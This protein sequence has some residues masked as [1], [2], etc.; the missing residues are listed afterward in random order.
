MKQLIL[1]LLLSLC[2]LSVNAQDYNEYLEAAQKHLNNGDYENA[3][4]SYNVYKRLTGRTIAKYE[5]IGVSKVIGQV[6]YIDM[7]FP[8]GTKW[9]SQNETQRCSFDNALK[10]Y[11][12]SVLP[13]DKQWQELSDWCNWKWYER[14]GIYGYVLTSKINGNSIFLPADIPY[15]QFHVKDSRFENAASASSLELYS[16]GAFFRGCIVSRSEQ[17]YV[18][19]VMN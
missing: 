18:R 3:E 14:D 5:N 10:I 7:G 15:W 13:S 11:N 1:A 12:N 6:G 8:S 9:K 16:D 19:L 2:V 4:K 17:Y